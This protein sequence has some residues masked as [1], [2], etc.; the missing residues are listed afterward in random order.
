V[1][2]LGG[3]VAV[4][5][6]S[7]YINIIASAGGLGTSITQQLSGASAAATTH[8][9]TA[10]RNFGAGMLGAV[11]GFA[12]PLLA[13]AG[14][15]GGLN[16]GKEIVAQASDL[17]E[18]GTKLAVVFGDAM[19]SVTDF[20]AGGAK[21]LGQTKLDVLNAAASFG[22]YGKAAGLQGAANADFSKSLV[23]LSTDL[24]SFYNTDPTAAADAIASGLR[25]EAEPLRQ[26]GILLDDATLRQKALE[27]GLIKT[28]KD[29]LTP[30]QKVLAAQA[31]IMEQSS[32][33]QGDFARTGAG[34]ANQQRILSA[35]WEDMKGKLGA[36]L[37]PVVTSVVTAMNDRLFPA[38]TTVGSGIAGVFS[39]LAHGDFKG[40]GALE[41]D[42]P[43]VG[44]LLAIHAGAQ[45]AAAA[46][47]TMATGDY[48]SMNY[49]SED[50]PVVGGLINIHKGAQDAFGAL[51]ILAT[52]D[53][54]GLN[55]FEEDSPFVSGLLG[56]REKVQ[57]FTSNL[58][59]DLS[60]GFN[61]AKPKL[62]A[63]G[64]SIGPALSGAFDKAKPVLM[65]VGS[66]LMDNLSA[67]FAQIGPVLKSVFSVIGPILSNL[68][69]GLGPI[70]SQLAPVIGQLLPLLNP[71]G[72][73]LKSLL[74]ILP[75][76][77]DAFGAI[78]VAISGALGKALGA[79]APLLPMIAGAITQIVT[80]LAQSLAEGLVS[81]VQALLPIVLSLADGLT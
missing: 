31:S 65:T 23:G 55:F 8:G 34:L 66:A 77:A 72:F 60:T 4:S 6:G 18:A 36:G 73:L 28:T 15:A 71:V 35:Q 39:I 16:F 19:T 58:G 80:L 57:A 50:S 38:L 70:F 62:A 17:N 30:Q 43:I 56:A 48:T 75:Q 63:F 21:A 9:N 54:S 1:R 27:L 46:L 67:T 64:A 10:G 14:L 2:A 74:P 42:S 78:A 13:T 41:E 12:G 68:M 49:F 76:L 37:L 40:L 32:L 61:A 5:L 11:K 44:G 20:A 47:H 45:D 81:I 22:V 51:K 29:A 79:V 25:G 3:T 53:Y 69:A 24:A 59:A 26:Y 7:A 52:G 33:A